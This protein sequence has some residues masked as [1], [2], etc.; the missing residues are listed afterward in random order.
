MFLFA[1][2][3]G[4]L[5]KQVHGLTRASESVTMLLGDPL[6]LSCVGEAGI[7]SM[8]SRSYELKFAFYQTVVSFPGI[9]CPVPDSYGRRPRP[10]K[11]NLLRSPEMLFIRKFFS[12]DE[13]PYDQWQRSRWFS[14][15]SGDFDSG[16]IVAEWVTAVVYDG[17]GDLPH[18][19]LDLEC[20]VGGT[21]TLGKPMGWINLSAMLNHAAGTYASLRIVLDYTG[22]NV[23]DQ[24]CA[25]VLLPRALIGE[26]GIMHDEE[27]RSTISRTVL[28]LV[29][30]VE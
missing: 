20:T 27:V 24:A 4:T 7:D 1:R 16:R 3:L 12:D 13:H 15:L 23:V 14:Q 26:E 28:A 18:F 30:A 29:E 22:S 19:N 25:D 6:N 5:Q 8:S 2:R 9:D 11:G 17:I 10:H 21:E